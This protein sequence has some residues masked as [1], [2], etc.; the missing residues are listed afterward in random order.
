MARDA[1]AF[2]MASSSFTKNNN[3]ITHTALDATNTRRAFMGTSS[4]FVASTLVTLP[5]F[6]EDSVDDLAMPTTGDK[7]DEVSFLCSNLFFKSPE[8]RQSQGCIPM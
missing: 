6:A 7:K 4:A 3:G 2:S 8:T 1:T 5:V